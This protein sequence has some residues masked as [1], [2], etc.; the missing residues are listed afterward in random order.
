MA[1]K[2]KSLREVQK[3]EGDSHRERVRCWSV[4]K[5]T[6]CVR[7]TTAAQEHFTCVTSTPHK[8]SP[9]NV[10]VPTFGYEKI[11]LQSRDSDDGHV[12]N[13]GQS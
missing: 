9:K 1:K 12:A 11:K 2:D 5:L 4:G 13:N 10:V 7:I 6:E 3:A 8:R